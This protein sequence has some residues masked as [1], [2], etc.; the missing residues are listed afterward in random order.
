MEVCLRA[1]VTM[2]S[3][4]FGKAGLTARSKTS[5]SRKNRGTTKKKRT[6]LEVKGQEHRRDIDVVILLGTPIIDKY[7]NPIHVHT[8]TFQY[9]HFVDGEKIQPFSSS[10]IR[11]GPRPNLETR[12]RPARCVDPNLSVSRGASEYDRRLLAEDYQERIFSH[13]ERQVKGDV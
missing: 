12:R 9:E 11:W 4:R 3:L 8:T 2:A 13:L 10:G 5:Y 1:V 7:Q 6:L